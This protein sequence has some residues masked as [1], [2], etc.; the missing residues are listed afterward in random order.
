MNYALR[1]RDLKRGSRNLMDINLPCRVLGDQRTA[2]K[3]RG[4]GDRDGELLMMI[5]LLHHLNH[6]G[7]P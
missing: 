3:T 7:L 6:L 4:T 5:Q 1:P 2:D